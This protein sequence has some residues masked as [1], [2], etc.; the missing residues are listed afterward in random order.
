MSTPDFQVMPPLTAI[1]EAELRASID[2]H[3]VQVPVLL[4]ENGA[5]IDGHH[6]S[7]LA[8][9]LGIPC[10]AEVRE[11]LSDEQK[12]TLAR[13]LN[14][15]RRHLTQAQRR[16]L[17]ASQ[18]R[19]TPQQS[20]NAIAKALGVSDMTVNAVRIDLESTSQIRKLEK[21]TGA[22]GKA[23]KQPAAKPKTEH[24]TKAATPREQSMDSVAAALWN[25]LATLYNDVICKGGYIHEVIDAL[26]ED[27]RQRAHELA[28]LI[29]TQLLNTSAIAFCEARLID[30]RERYEKDSRAARDEVLRYQ[31][32]SKGLP[33]LMTLDEYRLV[34]GC[35]HP[36]RANTVEPARLNEAFAIVKRLESTIDPR[37]PIAELRE[38]GWQK[39]SGRY[40][41]PKKADT[42]EGDRS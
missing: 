42:V 31:T 3:G 38:G 20:N 41:A 35:L 11:G 34:R 12:R 6:R 32:M 21:R 33:R 27:H 14:I 19:E 23:R 29:G 1:E 25:S 40:R 22:D 28:T 10:P 26:P 4:D 9:E 24:P 39:Y 7:K 2:M 18:L 5:V 16:E 36:D 17:I 30:V 8:S 13:T 37:T 15:A